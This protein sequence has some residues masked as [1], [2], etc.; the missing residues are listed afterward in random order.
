MFTFI[1]KGAGRINKGSFYRER[2]KHFIRKKT[3][4]LSLKD[5]IPSLIIIL[6][7]LFIKKEN[8]RVP[9]FGQFRK[10]GRFYGKKV[11]GGERIMK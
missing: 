4:I 3:R 6:L 8:G 2:K 1:F 10:I 5:L 11:V 7:L 9:S